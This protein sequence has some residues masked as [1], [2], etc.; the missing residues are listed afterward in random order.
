MHEIISSNTLSSSLLTVLHSQSQP[1]NTRDNAFTSVLPMEKNQG[2]KR[3][4]NLI[5]PHNGWNLGNSSTYVPIK[6][7]GEVSGKWVK[8]IFI[9][10]LTRII[11]PKQ[12][13]MLWCPTRHSSPFLW[14]LG[15]AASVYS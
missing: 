3:V 11:I 6:I 15:T 5:R 10:S 14:Y 9:C 2:L 4:A 8:F 1:T 13:P 7:Q 12:C